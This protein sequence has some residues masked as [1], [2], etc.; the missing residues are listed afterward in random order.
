MT[1]LAEDDGLG[2]GDG[3][4]DI[5]DGLELFFSAFAQHLVLLDGVHQAVSFSFS[6]LMILE[7]GTMCLAKSSTDSSKVAEKS[8][9]WQL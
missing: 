6:S 5:A 3:S 7:S 2:D 4:I 1:H 9:I 8:N